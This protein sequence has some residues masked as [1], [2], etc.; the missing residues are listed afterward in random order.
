MAYC[1]GLP[2][3]LPARCHHEFLELLEG[4]VANLVVALST[5]VALQPPSA[6]QRMRRGSSFVRPATGLSDASKAAG[7]RAGGSGAAVPVA[8]VAALDEQTLRQLC[9]RLN[10]CEWAGEQVTASGGV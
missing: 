7:G 4:Q 5:G 10:D 2:I 9:L 3:S 1:R 6:L 8:R